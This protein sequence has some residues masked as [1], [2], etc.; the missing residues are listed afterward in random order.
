M[1]NPNPAPA[2]APYRLLGGPGSPYSLKMRALLRYRRLPHRWIVPRSYLGAGGELE[3]AAKGQ[4]PVMHYPDGN[5]WS[6]STPLILDLEA[7]H[8]GERSVFP[9]DPGAAFLA[10]LI[11][12]LGDE[13]L[14]LAMFDLRWGTP[15]DQ[16]FC[17]RRQLSGWLSPIGREEL[18]AQIARFTKRQTRQRA[19][20]VDADSHITLMAHYH[21]V[22]DA[23]EAMQEHSLYLFGSRPSAADFGLYGQLSQCCID[24]SA[25]LIMRARAPRTYQW[26]Q[27][28]DDAGGVD[29]AWAPRAQWE[30]LVRPLLE[31]CGKHHLPLLRAHYEGIERGAKEFETVIDGRPWRG[32]PHAY[33]HHCLVWLR[34]AWQ[35]LPPGPRAEIEGLLRDTGCLPILEDRTPPTVAVAALAP[36]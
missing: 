21:A 16:A 26:V 17:A 4:I 34:R 36:Q 2:T 31:L 15:A 6:D 1:N 27:S 30:P 11:E 32:R 28:L 35:A 22:L 3:R 33:K 12:D 18:E 19:F 7:R 23:L 8:P 24:P 29:G 5:Y 25:S 13:M 10:S 9:D 14:V 20:L